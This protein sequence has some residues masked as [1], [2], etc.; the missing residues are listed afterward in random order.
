MQ[1]IKLATS[2]YGCSNLAKPSRYR[3]KIFSKR[4][5][6]TSLEGR[7]GIETDTFVIRIGES[8]FNE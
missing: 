1:N 7:S 6:S 2:T 5:D 3:N 8:F 4:F